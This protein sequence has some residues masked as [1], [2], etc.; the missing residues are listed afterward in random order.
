MASDS[1]GEG[2]ILW[3]DRK[4]HLWF[5]ISFTTYYIEDDCLMCRQGFL[6]TTVEQILLY[7]VVDIT[8]RQSLWGKI[9]G[10]GDIILKTRVDSTPEFTLKNI[11]EPMKV[12]KMLSIAV[13]NC[14]NQW[15]VVGKEFYGG[16]GPGPIDID[17]DGI[18]DFPRQ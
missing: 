14:R 17:G 18:P 12:R 6:N 11:K 10:T 3:K 13:E 7:R 16:P 8:F 1:A 2:K 15:N 9:F 5:P 4:H